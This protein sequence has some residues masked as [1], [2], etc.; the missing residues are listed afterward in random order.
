MSVLWSSGL[1]LFLSSEDRK[2][3]KTLL[4]RPSLWPLPGSRKKSSSPVCRSMY[5]RRNTCTATSGRHRHCQRLTVVSQSTGSASF[6]A[7]A[8][9]PGSLDKLTQGQ[10]FGLIIRVEARPVVRNFECRVIPGPVRC[11]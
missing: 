8:W 7:R 9:P 2:E 4:A 10:P 5:R 3:K 1:T 6:G 11:R